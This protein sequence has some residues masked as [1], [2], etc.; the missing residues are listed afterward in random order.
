[1]VLT[2]ICELRRRGGGTAVAALGADG[3]M[4]R[5]I[6]DVLTALETSGEPAGHRVLVD[7]RDG[8]VTIEIMNAIY[9]AAITAQT[10]TLQQPRDDP[11]RTHEGLVAAAPH[12]LEKHVSVGAFSI[13]EITT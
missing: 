12:F 8:R 9:Q 11:F 1:M 13:N 6:D 2:L 7:G 10:V 5:Q 4:A 3:G